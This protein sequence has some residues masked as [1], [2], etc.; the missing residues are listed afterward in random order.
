MANPALESNADVIGFDAH[1][2]PF[3]KPQLYSFTIELTENKNEKRSTSTI[4]RMGHRPH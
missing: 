4:A 3:P 2:S 1:N